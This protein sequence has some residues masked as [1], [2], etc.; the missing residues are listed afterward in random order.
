MSIHP[1][2]HRC[3]SKH[4]RLIDKLIVLSYGRVSCWLMST[5][6]MT[7]YSVR[8]PSPIVSA[9]QT[10]C[11]HSTQHHTTV[12]DSRHFTLQYGWTTDLSQLRDGFYADF[13]TTILITNSMLLYLEK[14]QKNIN[15]SNRY[16]TKCIPVW[17]ALSTLI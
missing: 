17:G 15:R 1:E 14:P 16:A 11:R 3:Q 10:M 6:V 13:V 9:H 12:L 2:P 4:A 5:S 8:T 7:M